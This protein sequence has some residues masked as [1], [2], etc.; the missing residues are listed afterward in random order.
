MMFNKVSDRRLPGPGR[1][2]RPDLSWRPSH[3]DDV[4]RPG[5]TVPDRDPGLRLRAWSARRR[6]ATIP[7]VR[8]PSRNLGRGPGLG[9]G[10][11]IGP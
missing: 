3:S 10:P 8:P 9:I 4:E 7:A 11:G 2:G 1:A 6:S 5:S